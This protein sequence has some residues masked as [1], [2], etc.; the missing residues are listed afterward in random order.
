MKNDRTI[1]VIYFTAGGMCVL[2][3]LNYFRHTNRR[4]A[5]AALMLC[6]AA[7]L[8]IA[9][10]V[11]IKKNRASQ[12]AAAFRTGGWSGGME[13]DG[14]EKYL[15]STP[16]LDFNSEEIKALVALKGW[17]D[18]DEDAK[19]RRIY[20]FVRDKT[21]FGFNLDDYI[22]ASI[23]LRGGRGQ[24]NN[25]AVVLTA[26]LRACSVPCRIHAYTAEKF[27]LDGI[28]N[29]FFYDKAPDSLLLMTVEIFYNGA[30]IETDAFVLDKP[31]LAG[32]R[33]LKPDVTDDFYGYGFAAQNFQ[34]VNTDWQGESVSVLR[35]AF[36]EDLGVFASPDELLGARTQNLR[37]ARAVLYSFVVRH[38]MNKNI[39]KIREKE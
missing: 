30:W 20:A 8:V 12:A 2:A 19:I 26:L 3:A 1:A 29:G 22:P 9:G 38:F 34:G 32:L 13:T 24:L 5:A 10:I 36:R 7:A 31:Y 33:Q 27:L 28:L 15:L 4:A 21:E 25:K 16:L 35:K 14:N 6:A 37:G 23:I 17:K 11:W 39:K 18:A